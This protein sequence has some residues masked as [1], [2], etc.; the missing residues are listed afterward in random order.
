MKKMLWRVGSYYGVTTLLFIVAWVWLAQSQ[1]SLLDLGW[2]SVFRPTC[3][4]LDRGGGG[5]VLP[6]DFSPSPNLD[7]RLDRGDV[8]H[9]RPADDIVW[10]GSLFH[11]NLLVLVTQTKIP[12]APEETGV[13]GWSGM[14]RV[15][16]RI[17]YALNHT[18]KIFRFPPDVA[19]HDNSGLVP[20]NGPA[21]FLHL[22]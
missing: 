16:A 15:S 18:D 22:F 8:D 20:R 4:H 12:G 21:V 6:L 14:R 10:G 19:N 3:G 9:P 5:S 17:Q 2:H 1:R 7:H 13:S 11:P